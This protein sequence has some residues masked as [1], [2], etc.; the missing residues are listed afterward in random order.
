MRCHPDKNPNGELEFK[1]VNW[2]YSLLTNAKE[3]R[4]YDEARAARVHL[5]TGDLPR[6]RQPKPHFESRCVLKSQRNC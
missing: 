4:E 5:D 3:K 2:A 1:K 6:P